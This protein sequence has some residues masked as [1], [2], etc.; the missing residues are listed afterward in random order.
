MIRIEAH[1]RE[2]RPVVYV[3]LIVIAIVL[4]LGLMRVRR[5]RRA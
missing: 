2:R 3:I 1:F 5:G 4:L